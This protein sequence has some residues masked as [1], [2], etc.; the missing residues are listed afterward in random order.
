MPKTIHIIPHTHWDREW[1]LSFQN[2]RYKLVKAID[3]LLEIM[4]SDPEFRYF[5]LDGQMAA[6]DD[7]L[8]IRPQNAAR[9]KDLALAGRIGLGPWYILMDEFLVSGETIVRNLQLGI[10]RASKFSGP[11]DIGYLPDMFGHIAQMPQILVQAGLKNAVVWRGVPWNISNHRFNW[12]SPDGTLIETE[13]LYSGYSNGATIP[14]S[15]SKALNYLENEIK[16]GSPFWSKSDDYL[17]MNGTDHMPPQANITDLV[18]DLNNSQDRYVF[19]LSDLTTYLATKD[20]QPIPTHIGELRSSARANLL[21]GVASNHMDIK[22]IAFETEN[23]IEKYAEPL[24]ALYLPKDKWPDSFFDLAWKNLIYNSAHD[25]SCA[26]SID[27]VVSQVD[28]R[29]KEARDLANSILNDVIDYVSTHSESNK[30]LLL[31]PSQYSVSGLAEIEINGNDIPEQTQSLEK[32]S[33]VNQL[34]GITLHAT[35]VKLALSQ[36]NS[37]KLDDSNF[38]NAI[39]ISEGENEITITIYTMSDP[40]PNFSLEDTKA[41]INQALDKQPNSKVAINLATEN[42]HRILAY[43]NDLPG[44]SLKEFSIVK[45]PDSVSVK[46]DSNEEIILKNKFYELSFDLSTGNFSLDGLSGFNSLEESGDQGDTY[47]YSPPVNDLIITSPLEVRFEVLE[48]GPLRAKVRVNRKYNWPEFV[49]AD[50]STRVGEKLHVVNSV[51]TLEAD[52]P[53]IKISTSFYNHAK[54]HRLRVTF[55]LSEPAEFSVAECAFA[56]VT[57]PLIAEEGISEKGLATF[58]SRRFV[59]A[60]NLILLKKGLPEYELTN[61]SQ[62]GDIIVA[63]ELALTLLRSTGMLSRLTTRYRP[64]PAGPTIPAASA[65][66]IGMIKS[67]YAICCKDVDPYELADRF[68]SPPMVIIGKGQKSIDATKF[69]VT[70]AIVSSIVRYKNYLE[71]RVFNPNQDETEVFVSGYNRGVMIDLRRKPLFTFDK[72]FKLRGFGIATFWLIDA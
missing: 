30:I 71:V 38:V 29:Y 61:L 12:Q 3:Q 70:G 5:H 23:L 58:P 41:L 64:L 62:T 18:K 50:S 68:L 60:G 15:T 34:S 66:Q 49:D 25:S 67:E 55:P 10:D 4:E 69:S 31:N 13:Y 63:H 32:L 54:D 40:N 37:T 28:V 35:E 33:L 72:S 51:I 44:Y 19:K 59:K 36:I 43:Y 24:A 14:Q 65:Q 57:R 39:D 16:N 8:E 27:D 26:C 21:M 1:Y 2:Y 52:S 7:Y 46:S 42:K 56:T 6:L 9:I 45:C 48:K 17:I 47:N 22:Q 20:T 53:L 11:V